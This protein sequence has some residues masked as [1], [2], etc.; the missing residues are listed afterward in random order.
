MLRE[1]KNA[2]VYAGVDR[3]S[4]ERV[5]PQI[6]KANLTMTTILSLFA[7]ILIAAMLIAS[8]APSGVMQNKQ[9]YLLGLIASLAIL[10]LSLTFAKR[11]D[12][13]VTWLVYL[14]YSIYYLYGILI[15][16]ITDPN[17]KTVT[18][19]VM[20]VFMPIL[21]IDRPI[22]I[23]SVTGGYIVMFII[24]C[25]LNKEGA[26]LSVDVIDAVIFGIL[27]SASAFVI[28]HMKVKS[29]IMEQK[30]HE[31]SKID[32]LTQIKNRNAYEFERD[33][34]PDK[35]KHSLAAIY[36]DVNGLHE[37]NNEEGHDSGDK[38]LKFIASEVKNTFSEQ[39]AYRIGGDEF[40]AFAPDKKD[41][42]LRLILDEMTKQ[43]EKQNY[44]VAIGYEISKTKY[45]SVDYLIN[46]AEKNMITD[47][48]RY[49]KDIANRELRN[50]NTDTT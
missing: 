38:M 28:N 37:I 25:F 15:G 24:L 26:V 1:I 50:A 10:I 33:S 19:M 14:S 44:H 34:V 36:I 5:R 4:F 18:F 29:F 13:L 39:F 35:C 48:K 31:I 40:V 42:E 23:I 9:V 11:S 41:E 21:F 20:L 6:Q 45:C 30:L 8:L 22:H 47:K 7:T 27:G 3:N 17:G 43:I 32:Q 2:F 16:A 12:A 46:S 49:Y